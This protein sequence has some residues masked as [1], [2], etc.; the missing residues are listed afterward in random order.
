MPPY[1]HNTGLEPSRSNGRRSPRHRIYFAK[2]KLSRQPLPT[3][4]LCA[5]RHAGSSCGGSGRRL[6]II[7]SMMLAGSL[8]ANLHPQAV[9]QKTD[10]RPGGRPHRPRRRQ[11]AWP[12]CPATFLVRV[13]LRRHIQPRR[14]RK[15]CPAE[16]KSPAV[17]LPTSRYW[18][19]MPLLLDGAT[20]FGNGAKTC[21]FDSQRSS[22]NDGRLD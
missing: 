3:S 17:S 2:T 6:R 7:T 14:A 20:T 5:G 11:T 13:L 1:H 15:S 12:V 9:T 18:C 22:A 19:P 10:Q 16:P 21:V 8:V 4:R